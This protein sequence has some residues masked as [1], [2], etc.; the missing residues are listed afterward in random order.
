MKTRHLNII[1]VTVILL[2]FL[3][4]SGINLWF[5]ESSL[6][7][8][9]T[10]TQSTVIYDIVCILLSFV[11]IIGLME[12]QKK[13]AQ[14]TAS[15]IFITT[16]VIVGYIILYRIEHPQGTCFALMPSVHYLDAVIPVGLLATI[17]LAVVT[18][19]KHCSTEET[20]TK[21]EKHED[22]VLF[23]SLYTNDILQ[24]MDKAEILSKQICDMENPEGAVGVAIT[25]QW[26][27]GKSWF[28]HAV[29]T[30]LL[31]QPG[32]K[33]CMTFSPWLHGETNISRDF[34]IQLSNELQQKGIYLHT[35]KTYLRE[36][37]RSEMG[38]W[39]NTLMAIHDIVA[40]YS[41]IEQH[42][43]SLKEEL[44]SCGFKIYVFIDDC[45]RLDH[46]ELKQVISLI[47][48]TGDFPNIVYIMTFC[49]ERL[50]QILAND[51][52]LSFVGKMFN[53]TYPLLPITNDV[54][55]RQLNKLIND[56]PDDS[57]DLFTGL[58]ISDYL[59]N[60]RELKKFWNMLFIDYHTQQHVL[61]MYNIVFRNY[62]LL[63]LLKYRYLS[64]Y[65]KLQNNPATLL[66]EKETGWDAPGWKLRGD[67]TNSLE[68]N[69]KGAG[70]ILSHLFPNKSNNISDAIAISNRQSFRTYFAHQPL[71][72]LITQE[73][74]SRAVS[75]QNL[76][77]QIGQWVNDGKKNVLN[78]LTLYHQGID[79]ATFYEALEAFVY[80]HIKKQPA[81]K[82]QE[83]QNREINRTN[84]PDTYLAASEFINKRHIISELVFQTV[85]PDFDWE[86]REL[87]ADNLP[88][89][90]AQTPH[91]LILM[92]LFNSRLRKEDNTDVYYQDLR[93]YYLQLW[94]RYRKEA[95]EHPLFVNNCIDI[96]LDTTFADC[97]SVMVE[98][99]LKENPEKWFRETVV[100]TRFGK[101]ERHMMILTQPSH[102]LFDTEKD[103]IP[104]IDS[105]IAAL[106]QH[107]PMLTEYKSLIQAL[108]GIISK[109]SLY[110]D[111]EK[112]QLEAIIND[113]LNPDHYPLLCQLIDKKDIT[114]P[115][116]DALRQLMGSDFW[117]NR[118]HVL[119]RVDHNSFYFAQTI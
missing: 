74:F 12:C 88:E 113:Q 63:E 4:H 72:S 65:I 98:P 81:Y 99:L 104:I 54:V 28:L 14:K 27:D 2:L 1:I 56:N 53:I 60:I 17:L 80:H 5:D 47:R 46:N 55:S 40:G 89:H 50:E 6:C 103:T 78:L 102:A 71:D 85:E 30:Q 34:F 112:D 16:I 87:V 67:Y 57:E 93:H 32:E 44:S 36:I 35:L 25:G 115:I 86:T 29:R 9:M 62:I 49:Q 18:S 94:E 15:T 21:Q 51:G 24:R 117:Q 107:R 105:L 8:I 59:P 108:Q 45:D 7:H 58:T 10:I 116:S 106:P 69:E 38:L 119:Q 90:V 66:E 100:M 22:H 97:Y 82:R 83:W 114:I 61:S 109:L 110:R 101:D 11:G 77:Q 52:G 64:I 96:I 13:Y 42:Y 37:G 118:S 43:L 73:E 20:T 95:S 19:K 111:V 23:D 75:Q 76:S 26:G 48:N 91:I 3:F 31:L 39:A 70:P 33:H 84:Y 68:E 41:S 92:A 79:H